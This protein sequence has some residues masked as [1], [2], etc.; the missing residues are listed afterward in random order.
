M[1]INNSKRDLR[2]AYSLDRELRDFKREHGLNVKH[3]LSDDDVRRMREVTRNLDNY[4]D[5]WGFKLISCDTRYGVYCTYKK[6]FE[7]YF[8]EDEKKEIKDEMWIHCMPS[9][10]DCTGQTFT[11]SIQFFE[12]PRGTWVYHFTAVDC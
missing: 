11:T 10:Y 4:E 12:T 6:F 5:E 3:G 7:E 2:F 1:I 8:T 9:Q